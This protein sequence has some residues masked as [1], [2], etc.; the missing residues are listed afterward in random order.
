MVF[1]FFIFFL[2]FPQ[3]WENFE[4]ALNLENQNIEGAIEIYKGLVQRSD[5]IGI[6]ANY[7]LA[8]LDDKNS[9]QW[10]LNLS[11]K[12]PQKKMLE[13]IFEILVDNKNKNAIENY[14]KIK[15]KFS[16]KFRKKIEEKIFLSMYENT[17][18]KIGL[19]KKA[20]KENQKSAIALSKLILKDEIKINKE[21]LRDLFKIG[22]NL[23]DLEFCQSLLDK[24]IFKD[25]LNEK[26]IFL[27]GRFYFF[28]KDY[29]ES[30][31]YFDLLKDEKSLFQKARVYLFLNEEEKAIETLKN[32][33]NELFN[34]AQYLIL[35]INL[36]NGELEKAEEVLKKIKRKQIKN[37]ATLNLAI[38]YNFYGKKEKAKFLLG[39]LKENKEV[40]FWKRRIEE[41]YEAK[42]ASDYSPF[43]FFYINK[44]PEFLKSDP[45]LNLDFKP[46]NFPQFLIYKGYF[47]EAL[48]FSD[49]LK[50]PPKELG[51]LYILQKRYNDAIKTIY[52]EASK[53]L[54]MDERNWNPEVLRIYFPKAYE[55][56]AKKLC[57]EY[58]IPLNL[59]WAIMRQESLFEEEAISEQGALGI[60]QVLPQNFLRYGEDLENPFDIEKNMKISLKYLKDLKEN[61]GDWIYVISAYNAG[62]DAVSLWLK[63]PIT[64]DL[65]SF[66][67][68]IPYFETKNYVK[69]VLYNWM[70]Y[71]ILYGEEDEK[72]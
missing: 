70:I 59:F 6:L 8:I 11:K 30:L 15:K 60:M 25:K 18:D 19:L 5:P 48:F 2:I 10:F 66:Y 68:T 62:E 22:L 9:F 3:D 52:P 35:R 61:F 13:E 72:F 37:Q 27:L 54:K 36:K 45:P 40:F 58:G 17:K 21:I 51:K 63:D 64:V 16:L 14:E 49:T 28:K 42:L 65:P 26:E 69:N 47:K 56:N 44:F 31:K 12:N 4:E 41:N 50:F 71:K 7:K 67:S 43:N 53:F 39:S 29:K 20:I 55:D 57:K 46:V 24:D 32:I 1:I 23:R 34:E 33:K 38:H